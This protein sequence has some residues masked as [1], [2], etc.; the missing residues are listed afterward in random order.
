MDRSHDILQFSAGKV[1]SISIGRSSK[2]SSKFAQKKHVFDI[3]FIQKAVTFFV[4][5]PL[6]KYTLKVSIESIIHLFQKYVTIIKCCP[7][8]IH[9]EVTGFAVQIRSPRSYWICCPDSIHPE[10]TGFAVQI[11]SPRRY[12]IWCPDSIHP[13]VLDLLS[14]FDPPRSYWICCPDSI[15]PWICCP[16]SIHPDVTGFAVQ[17]RSIQKVTAGFAVQIRSIHKVSGFDRST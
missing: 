16:D 10:V 11:R 2:S 8:S 14:R 6:K 17:I 7:D 5:N 15:H 1:W 4:Q 13:E 12:W 9:P 3:I